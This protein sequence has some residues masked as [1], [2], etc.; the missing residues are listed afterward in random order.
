MA[1]H[2]KLC[3]CRS[4]R[5]GLHRPAGGWQVRRANRRLRREARRALKQGREPTPKVAVGY[6]D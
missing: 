6:T 4:C 3:G 5:V 1:N 2:L